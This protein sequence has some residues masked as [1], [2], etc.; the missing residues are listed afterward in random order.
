MQ[1]KKS[2]RYLDRITVRLLDRQLESRCAKLGI[3]FQLRVELGCS[4]LARLMHWQLRFYSRLFE[5]C[6]LLQQR[7][8][9]IGRAIGQLL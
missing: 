7:L 1:N 3:D 2:I 8:R 6:P 9:E 5:I 4:E